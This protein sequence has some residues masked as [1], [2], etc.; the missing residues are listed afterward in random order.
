MVYD[1]HVIATLPPTTELLRNNYKIPLYFINER[2]FSTFSRIIDA[3]D[4]LRP[5]EVNKANNT[6]QF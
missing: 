6:T 2:A 5:F 3:I 1:Y 4:P